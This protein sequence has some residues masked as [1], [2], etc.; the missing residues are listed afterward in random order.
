VMTLRAALLT[1]VMLSTTA[2]GLTSP[3][4]A[5]TVAGPASATTAASATVRTKA[6]TSPNDFD[7]DG[8]DDVVVGDPFADEDKGAVHVISGQKVVPV[9]V[10]GLARGDGFGWSVRL[11][12]VNADACADLVVGAPFTDVR[13]SEDAGAAYVVYGGGAAPPR[14]LTA[15]EPQRDAHFGWSVAGKGDV[16]AI[17]A[18]YE[19]EARLADTG[20]VYV[21]KGEGRPRRI[22][23]ESQEVPGNGEVGDQFGWALAF[24]AGN[25]LVVG[26]PYENDDGAGRQVGSGKIDS[27]SVVV[28]ADA[29]APRLSGVKLDSPTDA[30]G[31]RYGYAVAYADGVGLA[32][33]A[34]GP[35]YVQ[36][37][38]PKLAPVRTVRK[39]GKQAFGFSLA[40]SADGRVAVGAPY[41]GGSY[42]LSFKDAGQEAT[43]GG[44]SDLGGYAV[45][46]SGN[47][48][49]V[50]RPDAAP[51]GQ[52]EVA[53]RNAEDTQ[54]VRP[55][56]GADFGMSLGG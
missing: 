48:L 11:A 30:D 6:C 16:I 34:P 55:A 18:P 2:A 56:K 37:L 31:D 21:A 13:G 22:S 14:Q 4:S 49:Y 32:V 40:V 9:P 29:L 41:G 20:A 33:G 10:P 46:F 8:V 28:I 24:G 5:T 25:Q 3:A 52:V 12:K 1:A 26:V 42:L 38:N 54:Q 23:Q 43:I 19:D 15:S 27:G 45:A 35:G 53:G 44:T 7:G 36:L 17:G 47:R 51:Y 50:G 39:G